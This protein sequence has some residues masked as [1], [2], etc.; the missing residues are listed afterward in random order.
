MYSLYANDDDILY[1]VQKFILDSEEDIEILPKTVKAGS[2][3]LIIETSD[4]YVLN[5]KAE[6]IKS[7]NP[8]AIGAFLEWGSF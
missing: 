2:S 4:I 8:G 7:K 5:H 6:W 1:G 3:A